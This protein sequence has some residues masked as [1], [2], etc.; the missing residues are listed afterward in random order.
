V[1]YKTSIEVAIKGAKDLRDFQQQLK[2]TS[3][4]V[5]VQNKLLRNLAKVNSVDL[6]P[7]IRNLNQALGEATQKFNQSVLGTKAATDA[8]RNL[9]VAERAVNKELQ[10]RSKL[11]N[12][13]RGVNPSQYGQPAGPKLLA[14]QTS[15]IAEDGTGTLK[16]QRVNIQKR[17][18]G[19][20]GSG[21]FIGGDGEAPLPSYFND[22]LRLYPGVFT[23]GTQ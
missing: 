9:V 4:D 1:A 12:S 8:A 22:P 10:E 13:I 7:S 19:L 21:V 20:Y 14:G 6:L 5:N 3:D 18:F 16:G 15:S 11:L 2:K 23:G 17:L